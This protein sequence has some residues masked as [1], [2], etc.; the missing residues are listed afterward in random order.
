MVNCCALAAVVASTLATAMATTEAPSR[1]II[2]CMFFPP[3][4]PRSSGVLTFGKQVPDPDQRDVRYVGD[5]HQGDEIDYHEWN[6]AAI[7]RL[8][9]E[10]EH[11]LRDEYIDAERRVK[12]A[13][14]QVHRHHD[15]EV[16]RVDAGRLHDR[17][18]ERAQQQD[19]R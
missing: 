10:A 11:R 13:D 17:H 8:E 14:R 15:A 1:P 12:Q 2:A 6:D 18:Q 16:H 9:L 5:Q 3:W 4:L 19:R 7:D